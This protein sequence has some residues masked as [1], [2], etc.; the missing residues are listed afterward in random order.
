[1]PAA[2]AE[3]VT[4]PDA[5]ADM[6]QTMHDIDADIDPDAVESFVV[7]DSDSDVEDSVRS[8]RLLSMI[9]PMLQSPPCKQEIIEGP[10]LP[11]PLQPPPGLRGIAPPMKAPGWLTARPPS[12]DPLEVMHSVIA[13]DAV[14]HSA[15]VQT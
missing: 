5:E 1:M 14:A 8:Q 12:S 9:A 10:P 3:S 13:A 7:H 6:C 15:G 11:P 2:E 4:L